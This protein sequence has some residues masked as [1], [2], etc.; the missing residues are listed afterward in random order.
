MRN[1]VIN[2]L[3]KLPAEPV[4]Q[5]NEALQLYLQTP[6]HNRSIARYHNNAG[7]SDQR[8]SELLYDLKAAHQI[9][10]SDIVQESPV[11]M[12][13]VK[14]PVPF[15]LPEFSKGTKGNKERR[16]Y[17]EEHGLTAASNKNVDLD[18]AIKAHLES[19]A[20]EVE[21]ETEVEVEAETE[22]EEEVE[23]ETEIKTPT[24]KKK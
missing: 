17:V 1:K 11:Q 8:L 6:G 3:S 7:Y 16:D 5:F 20:P 14:T 15:T 13:V 9:T 19:A 21:V 2:F 12:K 10:A 24:A 4:A 18:A 22:V 23:A